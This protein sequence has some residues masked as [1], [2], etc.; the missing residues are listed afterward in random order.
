MEFQIKMNSG[1]RIQQENTALLKLE[2]VYN[3]DDA[4]FYLGKRAV[5]V[6]KAHKKIAKGGHEKTRVS[7]LMKEFLIWF[8][9]QV[10]AIWGRIT[11]VHGNS[12]AVRAK[13]STLFGNS[14]LIFELS[15]TTTFRRRPWA[16]VFVSCST[17]AIPNC[18]FVK[19]AELL[20]YNE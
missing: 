4:K 5:Y 9:L 15:S 12:G 3:Q 8:I 17:Q 13:V 19:M 20:S 11:R 6:Y 14:I 1:Q 18:L 10:R 2:G 7:F 16:S